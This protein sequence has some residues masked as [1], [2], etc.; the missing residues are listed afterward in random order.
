[1]YFDEYNPV[2][3]FTTGFK[4]IINCCVISLSKYQRIQIEYNDYI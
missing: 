2:N 1:M 3:A 4:V